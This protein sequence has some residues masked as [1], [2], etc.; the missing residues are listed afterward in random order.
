[1]KTPKETLPPSKID[2]VK[3]WESLREYLK[4][5]ALRAEEEH[6]DIYEDLK[7]LFEDAGL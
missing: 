6:T 4:Q 3:D 2:D 7:T 1:M 5:L